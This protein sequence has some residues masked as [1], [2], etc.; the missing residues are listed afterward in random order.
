MNRFAV[1]EDAASEVLKIYELEKTSFE[2]SYDG[3]PKYKNYMIERL[4]KGK[5]FN[6]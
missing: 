1:E 3:H 4:H 5:D 6:I 2:M